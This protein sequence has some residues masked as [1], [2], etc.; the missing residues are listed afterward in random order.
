MLRKAWFLRRSCKA[1]DDAERPRDGSQ[2]R[3]GQHAL[4]KQLHNASYMVAD[5]G[6]GGLP[7][8]ND[9]RKVEGGRVG[10]D[11]SDEQTLGPSS[12]DDWPLQGVKMLPD[13]FCIGRNRERGGLGAGKVGH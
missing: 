8:R 11:A 13:T 7:T 6:A 5:L 3:P 9:N 2:H 4:R 12:I 1:T 10:P